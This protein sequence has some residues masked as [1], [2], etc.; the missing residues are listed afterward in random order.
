MYQEQVVLGTFASSRIVQDVSRYIHNALFQAFV[1]KLS[2]TAARYRDWLI[3]LKVK[4]N[5]FICLE[6]LYDAAFRHDFKLFGRKIN[7]SRL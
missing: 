3:D 1:K 2:V 6:V 5:Y 4:Q 7:L